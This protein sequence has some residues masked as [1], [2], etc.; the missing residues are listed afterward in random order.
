MRD[1]SSG[2]VL[3]GRQSCAMIQDGQ[4]RPGVR[5][6]VH[7]SKPSADPSHLAAHL[8]A[9]SVPSWRVTSLALAL[10]LWYRHG[11]MCFLLVAMAWPKRSSGSMLQKL[12][13]VHSQKAA[14]CL[15][16]HL[17]RRR[18][19]VKWATERLDKELQ[20]AWRVLLPPSPRQEIA[21]SLGGGPC[22]SVLGYH[23]SACSGFLLP[24]EVV[25]CSYLPEPGLRA[26]CVR[27]LRE[28]WDS[29][30]RR[31]LDPIPEEE[32]TRTWGFRSRCKTSA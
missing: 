22:R 21:E 12:S 26:H 15:R 24:P 23:A 11:G 19:Y 1:S 28:Q 5:V 16:W 27:L 30:A 17:Q 18:L 9:L 32:K 20:G 8:G 31:N 25:S 10:C 4:P 14:L 13:L 3:K 29:E 6:L 7:E 2:T